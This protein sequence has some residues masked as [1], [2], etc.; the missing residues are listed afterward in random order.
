MEEESRMD[1]KK[2]PARAVIVDDD[3]EMVSLLQDFLTAQGYLVDAFLRAQEALSWLNNRPA[4]YL[5]ELSFVISD[6]RMPDL[7]GLGFLQEVHANLPT[8]PVILATAFGS[9]ENALDAMRKGAFDYVTKP[10]QLKELSLTLN[11][12]REFSDLRKENE[13]L[14]EQIRKDWNFSGIIGRSRKMHE[15]YALIEKIAPTTASILITGESGTGKE[16]VANAI[17]EKSARKKE[18]FLAINCSAI[19]EPLLESEL[20][21]HQKGAFTG[22]HQSKPG[23]L[24]EADGG[25]FFLDEIGDLSLPLQAKLLR[26]L[27]NKEIRPVGARDAQARKVDV[28]ILAATHKDLSRGIHEGWFRED[29]YY[30][31]N[32]IPLRLPPLRERPED[33]SILTR[34][35]IE[36][37][38]RQHGLSVKRISAHALKKLMQFGWPGN[39]RQLENVIERA[40]V[41]S[42]G[43]CIEESSLIA[44]DEE[45]LETS[46]ESHLQFG[47][48]IPLRDLEDRYIQHVLQRTQHNKE[49]AAKVLG[50]SRRTLYRRLDS[51][52]S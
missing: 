49:E 10:F 8:T 51:P 34:H 32:V 21:G 16:L 52:E 33:I 46:R 4:A 42:S 24:E 40:A 41:L 17:H 7:D 27:Q 48:L 35:F 14:R 36:K 43:E 28:R 1:A 39:V 44:L 2:N 29:L 22:A 13:R 30:R 3:S 6:I 12:A 15:L 19:P 20:F 37:A 45:N 5:A 50:I 9:I 18:P 11:R 25:T 26:F 23:L 38:A 31:L 47:H